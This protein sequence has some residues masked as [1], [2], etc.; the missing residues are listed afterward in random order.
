MAEPMD[1]DNLVSSE[2]SN[3]GLKIYLHPLVILNISDHHTRVKMRD[4]LGGTKDKDGY[5]I[6][7]ILLGTQ[8]GP[9]IHLR[10]SFEVPSVIEDGTIKME[11]EYIEKKSSQ[12]KEVFPDYEILGWYSTGTCVSEG[13]TKTQKELMNFNE[14]PLFLLCGTDLDSRPR[15]LPI[16]IYEGIVNLSGDTANIMFAKTNY[17]IDTEESER[18]S[19]E[20]IA[21]VRDSAETSGSSLVPHISSLENAIFMLNNRVEA[22]TQYLQAVQD[23]KVEVDYDVLRQVSSVVNR[24]PTVDSPKFTSEFKTELNESLLIAYLSTLTKGTNQLNELTDKFNLVTDKRRR[25]FM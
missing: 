6:V 1:I 5:R 15:D 21:N 19:T 18:V 13:D 24:L 3:S 8:D 12:Y 2:K 7:G 10:T 20:N 23:E 4:G 11:T 14:N 16:T 17:D 25:G 22:I 9:N